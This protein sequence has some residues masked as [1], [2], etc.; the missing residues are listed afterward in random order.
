[1]K[2]I[3]QCKDK[4]EVNEYFQDQDKKLWNEKYKFV[5]GEMDK[6]WAYARDRQELIEKCGDRLRKI[7]EAVK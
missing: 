5:Y 3:T 6:I 2:K 4:E 7:K 1:M